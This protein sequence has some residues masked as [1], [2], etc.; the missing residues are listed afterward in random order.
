MHQIGHIGSVALCISLVL[1]CSGGDDTEKTSTDEGG[2]AGAAGDENGRAGESAGGRTRTRDGEGG[3][4]GSSGE[5]PRQETTGGTEVSAGGNDA[6]GGARDASGSSAGEY[7][8]AG[9]GLG[10]EDGLGGQDGGSA[11]L[12]TGTEGG[13]APL[14]AGGAPQGE[15]ESSIGGMAGTMST[16]GG[17]D[18][19]GGRASDPVN[20]PAPIVCEHRG[21]GDA[22]EVGPNEAYENLGDVPWY[23][24]LPGDTVRIHY[25]TEPYREY[26][27]FSASG[28]AEQPIRICGVPGPNGELPVLDGDGASTSENSRWPMYE[29]L[30]DLG[31]ITVG[32]NDDNEYGYRPEHIVIE[33]LELRGANVDN[34]HTR[35]SGESLAW[36]D[37]AAGIIIVP[38]ADITVR[39]C[40]ITDNGN[41]LFTLSKD[42]VEGTL[43]RDV[44]LEACHIYGNGMVD[45]D[46][47]H[48]VYTQALGVTIQ[49][50]KFGRLRDGALGIN[51]KDRSAG[52]VIRYNWIDGTVRPLDLV[53]AQEH[54]EAATA[55]ERY[56]ETFVYGNVIIN[57]S[58]D[59]R[60]VVHYGGDTL[61]FEQNFRK[62]TLYFFNNTMFVDL[63]L[64]ESYETTLV[65]LDT[66]DET[67]E[68]F[69]N[70]VWAPNTTTIQVVR[71][72]GNLRLGVNWIN[73]GWVAHSADG[74]TGT[75]EGAENIIEGA[76]PGLDPETYVPREESPVID[77]AQAAVGSAEDYPV[78]VE[79]SERA[80]GTDRVQNGDAADLGAFEAR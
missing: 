28:D 52:T 63:S 9:R 38:A 65:N 24:L 50:N 35:V 74:F 13:R 79:F 60:R 1:G 58:G 71:E 21:S 27:L 3:T 29:P 10:G 12:E 39:G 36:D 43:V 55:D 45:S 67:L 25:R 40:V 54:T 18:N 66:N 46:N 34:N 20:V 72:A 26:F 64:D 19:A 70:V 59:G 56:R 14:E 4:A 61:G 78:D 2:R 41:G 7:S 17:S 44:L 11:G 73:S 57:V 33:G 23:A 5:A 48:N 80:Y 31:L 53:D 8:L 68:F 47:K 77:R 51:V 37:G 62:G 22:Y 16:A 30:Q 42:E 15:D 76:D 75:V 6:E 49:F 69:N 32:A